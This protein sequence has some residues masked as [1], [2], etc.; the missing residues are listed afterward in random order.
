[1]QIYKVTG[2]LSWVAECTNPREVA[3]AIEQILNAGL[4][5]T[6]VHPYAP[7]KEGGIT[8]ISEGQKFIVVGMAPNVIK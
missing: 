2:D 8:Q 7:Y 4:R 5:V 6:S 1:M 3:S